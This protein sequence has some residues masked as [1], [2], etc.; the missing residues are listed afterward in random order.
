MHYC[1]EQEQ[2]TEAQRITV[3]FFFFLYT[4][5]TRPY[6]STNTLKFIKNY[7]LYGILIKAQFVWVKCSSGTCEMF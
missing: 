3:R 1:C 7:L 5:S 4:I 6:I 2:V